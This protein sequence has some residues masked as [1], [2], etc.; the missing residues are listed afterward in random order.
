M[1]EQ[2]RGIVEV[3]AMG[4][5]VALCAAIPIGAIWMVAKWAEDRFGDMGSIT[6]AIIGIL[7]VLTIIVLAIV[8]LGARI[9]RAGVVDTIKGQQITQQG[10]T[11]AV[12]DITQAIRGELTVSAR[13][14]ATYERDVQNWANRKAALM[15]RDQQQLPAPA[16]ADVDAEVSWY[17]V[18]S[19]QSIDYEE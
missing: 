11:A 6:V 18:R 16:D 12:K 1:N 3:L 14:A 13:S 9:Y 5:M 7:L 4:V 15:I 2:R 10:N 19:T 17:E 8:M